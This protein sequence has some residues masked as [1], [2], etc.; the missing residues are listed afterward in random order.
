MDSS[1]IFY[2]YLGLY[3]KHKENLLSDIIFCLWQTYPYIGQ[4]IFD[5]IFF[6]GF[7]NKNIEL[8]HII[9][10]FSSEEGRNDFVFY[11]SNGIYILESKIENENII[12]A[13]KYLS[14]VGN[15]HSHIRYITPK[16]QSGLEDR[17]LHSHNIIC[18]Y[19][20]DLID[21]LYQLSLNKNIGIE[22]Q[23]F[24]I[25]GILNSSSLDLGFKK[26]ESEVDAINK[27]NPF[28]EIFSSIVSS[29][30]FKKKNDWEY[31]NY[32]SLIYNNIWFCLKFCP[33]KGSF[34]CFCHDKKQKIQY[35]K[36]SNIRNI[37]YLGDY[38]HDT[39]LY[40]ELIYDDISNI[41]EIEEIMRIFLINFLF[42]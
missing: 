28:I 8:Y 29:K 14:I 22:S 16:Y 12:K 38:F 31:G 40:Y 7:N 25:S 42:E 39:N 9:R 1:N 35:Q 24:F 10:E 5:C 37:R 4:Y 27:F 20:D 30:E 32:L 11:T 19:W 17:L 33:I 34:L 3:K 18:I 15:D 13:K 21:R 36:L 2:Y 26:K 41:S 23:L 6:D